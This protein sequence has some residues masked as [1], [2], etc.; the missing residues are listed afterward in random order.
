[1]INKKAI[2]GNFLIILLIVTTI[3]STSTLAKTNSVPSIEIAQNENV[4]DILFS[5]PEDVYL[6]DDTLD[7]SVIGE[8]AELESIFYQDSQS[9]EERDVFWN[10][11]KIKA[12]INGEANSDFRIAINYQG[13]SKKHKCSDLIYYEQTFKIYTPIKVEQA[14]KAVLD[15]KDMTQ[16]ATEQ[17]SI[18]NMLKDKSLLITL[19][20]FFGFG[21]LLAFTPCM[22]PVIP[23]LSAIIL[24]KQENISVKRGILLSLTYVLSMSLVYAVAGILAASLGSNIQAFF[25]QTWIIILFSAFFFILSLAMFGT[26]NI[27]MPKKLQS[28][29]TAK[30]TCSDKRSYFSVAM[31]GSL[32][33]LIVGPCV[34]PPLA[35]ALIYISQTGNELIGGLS[36][37][38]MSIGMGIPLLLLG[39]GAGKL[40]PKPGQ[41]MESVKLIF[42]FVMLGFS[43]WVLSRII[44][45]ELVLFLW[46]I[47]LV[48]ASVFMDLFDHRNIMESHLEYRLKKLVAL[49]SL[50][51]GVM[52]IVGSIGGARDIKSPLEPFVSKTA[53][54]VSSNGVQF[55]TISAKDI[56]V[57]IESS[58]KPIMFVFTADWCDNCKALQK[59][60]FS[61]NDVATELLGF[62]TYK[63]DV[64]ANTDEDRALL[65]KYA[66]FGPPGIIFFDKNKNEL[67]SH[68]FIGYKEKHIFLEHVEIVKKIIEK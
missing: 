59:D 36:L 34:A 31:L 48:I 64:T 46:G 15:N 26:F 19:F 22:L 25:Q 45:P 3:F 13:C 42:G 50:I 14:D 7:V 21:L 54:T 11:A 20:T 57:V 55:E 56:Q 61:K 51:F 2:K 41:W 47:L 43:I 29:L 37:F 32:S 4:F 33:A 12:I 10:S 38:I 66:L 63:I 52:L 62:D 39:A 30:S 44:E 40:L 8:N 6:A 1:M 53:K 68:R 9:F 67:S 58:S 49:L 16:S 23:I 27:E 35:G 28:I 60:V 5:I 17:D 24:C 18:V 65:K